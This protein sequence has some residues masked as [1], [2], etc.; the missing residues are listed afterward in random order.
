MGC[1]NCKCSSKKVQPENIL[2]K[3]IE[4]NK[5]EA[6]K[7]EII[8][9]NISSYIDENNTMLKSVEVILEDRIIEIDNIDKNLEVDIDYIVK[10]LIDNSLI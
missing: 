7:S 6:I 3:Q 5:K 8:D 10:Y 9:Y 1:P 4:Q 2:N